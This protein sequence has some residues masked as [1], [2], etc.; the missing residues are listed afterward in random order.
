MLPIHFAP[1]QGYTDYVYRGVHHAVAGGVACYYTPFVRLEKDGTLRNKDLRDVLP[2]NNKEVP[3]VP[4]IIAADRDE[5]CRLSDLL[6]QQGWQRLDFNMGCP[7]PMQT[8]AGRGSGLLP[9]PDRVAEIVAEMKARPEVHYSLKMRSGLEHSDEA[10]ALLP[11]LNEAPLVHIALH[12]RV[13]VQQYKGVPDREGAFS[14][15]YEQ[16]RLPLLYNGDIVAVEQIEDLERR[17]PR[18]AGVMIGRGLLAHPTLAADYARRSGLPARAEGEV[19]GAKVLGGTDCSAEDFGSA[20]SGGT[21]LSSEVFGGEDWG[22]EADRLNVVLQMHSQIF[23]HSLATLQGDVQIL[24]RMH[25]F[26]EYQTDILPRKTY[27]RLM[28]CGNVKNYRAELSALP[29]PQTR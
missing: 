19:V 16:C 6:Q 13:G 17:F 11:L 21:D 27:K 5:F 15:F 10:L 2:E 22:A 14:Q 12:A 7:F 8:H 4:Q 24:N 28:K 18:L 1:L 26:W 29:T 20:V 23:A 9:H 25:A 3:V